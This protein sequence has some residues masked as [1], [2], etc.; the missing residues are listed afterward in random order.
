MAEQQKTKT[1]ATKSTKTAGKVRPIVKKMYLRAQ[2]A[3]AEGRPIAYGMVAS[4]YEEILRAMDITPIWTE[5]Y[6]ALTAAKQ[7]AEPYITKAEAEG[8]SNVLCKYAMVGIGFDAI[9]AE[10]GKIPEGAPDGGMAQPTMLLGSSAV[11][12]P[13]FKWYQ[14]LGRY[15]DTPIHCIDVVYPN[16]NHFTL[17]MRDYYVKYQTEQFKEL[18]NFLEKTTG[19]KMDWERLDHIMDIADETIQVW[20]DAYQLRKA[21]PCPMPSQDHFS[22]MVPAYYLLGEQE[23]LD[24]YRELHDELKERVDNKVGAVENEKYRLLWG[25][26][27]PPWH[28]LSIFNYFESLGAVFTIETS[29]HPPEP[30]EPMGKDVHPLKRLSSRVVDRAMKAQAR[31]KEGCGDSRVQQILDLLKEYNN[32][33]MMMHQARSCRAMSLGQIHFKNMVQEH[34]KVPTMFMES[35]IVDV[36]DYSEAQT[37]MQVDAFVDAVESYAQSLN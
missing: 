26:G 37:K 33:G 16:S 27:L 24:F 21:T 28:T 22:C 25:G 18:V 4:Q 2:E 23:A 13:R 1:T 20:W 15:M 8:F 17:E 34:I 10:T 19:T 30:L 12:D 3:A 11:C 35:D 32:V 36:R 5:N 31:A 14:T 6:A 29:Y 9:R 7:V